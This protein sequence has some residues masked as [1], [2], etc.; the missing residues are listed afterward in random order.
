MKL[1]W[2]KLC[3]QCVF[4][5]LSVVLSGISKVSLRLSSPLEGQMVVKVIILEDDVGWTCGIILAFGLIKW[6]R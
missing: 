4:K 3:V 6:V 1:G 5:W 2:L